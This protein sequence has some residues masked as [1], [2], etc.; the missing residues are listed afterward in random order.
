MISV[1]IGI[2]NNISRPN[3][4]AP[5]ATPLRE[6]EE[7]H[8]I[9]RMAFLTGLNARQQNLSCL[10]RRFRFVAGTAFF[11]LVGGMIKPAIV[12]EPGNLANGYD[13]KIQS[14]PAAWPNNL[15]AIETGTVS[16]ENRPDRVITAGIASARCK[17]IS[18]DGPRATILAGPPTLH[19]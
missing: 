1:R 6:V 4:K 16:G 17:L 18:P 2:F 15:M 11:S 14:R 5:G 13:V 8:R 19:S 12:H 10:F 7:A 3:T 9:A